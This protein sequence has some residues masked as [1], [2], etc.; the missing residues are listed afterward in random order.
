MVQY[1]QKPARHGLGLESR[2]LLLVSWSRGTEGW[3]EGEKD[4]F[5][6]LSTLLHGQSG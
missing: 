1:R 4:Y 2:L 5:V 6:L 3:G